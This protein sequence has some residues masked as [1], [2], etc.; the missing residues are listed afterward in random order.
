MTASLLLPQIT[1]DPWE[2]AQK[3]QLPDP[4]ELTIDIQST[5]IQHQPVVLQLCTLKLLPPAAQVQPKAKATKKSIKTATPKRTT[6][7]INKATTQRGSKGSKKST[8]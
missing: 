1:P 2:Q 8:A 4:W 3:A 6:K 7:P 5:P